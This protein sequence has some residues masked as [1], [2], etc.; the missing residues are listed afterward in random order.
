MPIKKKAAK[1][2]TK[3]RVNKYDEKLQVNGSFEDLV[4]ELVTPNKTAKKK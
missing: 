3:K 4:K 1:K 2:P